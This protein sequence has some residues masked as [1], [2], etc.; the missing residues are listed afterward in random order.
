MLLELF[1][2]KYSACASGN[3]IYIHDAEVLYLMLII[4]EDDLN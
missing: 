3:A 1:V 4:N 2:V